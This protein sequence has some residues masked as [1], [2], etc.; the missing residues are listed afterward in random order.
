MLRFVI[1]G[2]LFDQNM[3]GYEIKQMMLNSTSNFIDAS[4]GSIY[5][6]LKKLEKDGLI[7]FAEFI[8]GSRYKKLY[9]ITEKGKEE[10]LIWLKKPCVFTPFNYEYLTKLFFY[11]HLE[12][13]EIL[14]LINS[15]TTTV[16]AEL[17]KLKRIEDECRQY[18]KFFDYATLR[19]GKEYYEMIIK[20]YEKLIEAMKNNSFASLR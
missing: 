15:F 17:E 9:S 18:M 20:W 7:S 8:E 3:T 13:N 5:P 4:F 10:F 14:Q 16:N 1:L 6:A 2:F 11:N 12:K 19:F